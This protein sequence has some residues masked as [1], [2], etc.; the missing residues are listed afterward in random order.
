M[1]SCP[2]I[3][4]P[5]WQELK[6]HPDI[7]TFQAFKDFYESGS[8]R[9][10]QE[11][12][13]KI[14]DRQSPLISLVP[15]DNSLTEL[16]KEYD[17]TG[18][19]LNEDSI[20]NDRANEFAN[21]LSSS[22]GVDYAVITAE[23]AKTITKD[24]TNPWTGQAGFFF[25]GKVYFI[26]GKLTT[27]LVLHEFAHPV[28]RNIAKTN[29]A[30]LN[31]LF[32]QVL[33][34]KEG[35]DIVND[36][37]ENYSELQEGSDMFKEE[38]IV[39]ALE[40][41]AQNKLSN[42]K[43][44]TGFAKVI[45]N[46][47]YAIKQLLRKVFGK[48][49]KVSKLSAD[50][51]LGELADILVKGDLLTLDN[52]LI[53][54][55][56]IVAY[57]KEVIKALTEDIEHI[58]KDQVQETIN[59]FYD[60]IGNH[61]NMLLKNRNYEEL[62]R[63]LT[64]ESGTG[65]LQAM[66]G[67]LAAWQTTVIREAE[68]LQD[69]VSEARSRS[70]ALANTLFTLQSVMGKIKDHVLDIEK[71]KDTQ[72]N[73]HKAHY[74]EQMVNYW[75]G[76]I[77]EFNTSLIN[78]D[79]PNDS[80]VVSLVSGIKRDIEKSQGSI[81]RMMEAGAIDGLW[82]QLEP[83]NRNISER[84]SRMI[85]KLED[86][87]PDAS[88]PDALRKKIDT[89]YKEFH[90]M[91]KVELD[92][93]NALSKEFDE[94]GG[95]TVMKQ[96]EYDKLLA[97]T[98]EGLSVTK[99]KIKGLIKGQI[100][101]ANFFNSY[102]EG[103]L[104]NTDP[105]V[106]GL[107]LYTKNAI[108]EVM[109]VSQQKFNTFAEE[110]RPLL[111]KAGYNPRQVGKLG[112]DVGFLDT[113]S[114][115]DPDTK[116]LV[117]R[118]VWTLLNPFKN[119]RYDEDRLEKAVKDTYENYIQTNTK[120][121]E[122][123]HIEAKAKY[124]QWKQDYMHQEYIPEYYKRKELL[125]KDDLGKAAGAWMDDFFQRL[126]EVTEPN[127]TEI[128][129]LD[130]HDM[131]D[132]LWR[133][134]R[135]KF[136]MYTE[137]GQ[138]K[139]DL[140]VID[141]VTKR[142][143]PS[144]L[145]MAKRLREY[146]NE[147][148]EFYEWK[149]RKNAFEQAYRDFQ[150]ELLGEGIDEKHADYKTRMD[151]WKEKNTRKVIKQEYY[152]EKRRILAEIKAI[153]S[154]LDKKDQDELDQAKVWED[155]LDN[156]GGFRDSDGQIQGQE[157]AEGAVAT[158]KELQE[159]LLKLKKN[160]AGRSGLTPV[161]S[162]RL[163]EILAA[164]I[165]RD[166]TAQE[167]AEMRGYFEKRNNKGLNAVDRADLDRLYAELG[168]LSARESTEYYADIVN[169][170]LSKLNTKSLVVE[171]NKGSITPEEADYLLQDHVINP[172]LAQDA[173][174]AEWFEKNHIRVE[175]WNSTSKK[176]EMKWERLY[177]WNVTKPAD[178]NMQEKYEIKDSVGTVLDTVEG[179]PSM[180]Y[181]YR[182]VKPKYRTR[183]ITGV[184]KS[185]RGRWLPKTMAEKAKDDRYQNEEYYNLQKNNPALFAVLEKLKE[186]HL[187]NQE[188]L[189]YNA[190][191]Y[192]DFPRFQ[193][194]M[195]EGLQSKSPKELKEKGISKLSWLARRI[196][197]FYKREADDVQSGLNDDEKFNLVR[198]DMFDNEITNVPIAGLYNLDYGDVSTDITLS[199][200]RYMYSA[201]RQK[202]LIKISPFVRS[203][204]KTVKNPLNAPKDL[205]KVKRD[206]FVNRQVIKYLPKK[207]GANVRLRAI[208][209][210]ITREFEGQ[211]QTGLG[212]DVPWLNNLANLLFKRASFSFFALNI[213]SALKNS[214]GM[215]FQHMI[216][217]AGGE[218]IDLPNLGKGKLWAYKAMSEYSAKQLYQKRGALD[219]TQQIIE[220]FDPIQGRFEEKFGERLSRTAAADAASASWLY[221]FRKWVEIQAGLELFGGM[222]YKVKLNRTMP[223][224]SVEEIS[225]M[226]AWEVVDNQLQLK[227]GID[228]RYSNKP[229]EHVV[230]PEDT[231]ES[232]A[233]QYNMPL[234][235]MQDILKNKDLMI[236]TLEVENE[237]VNRLEEL[238]ELG[239]LES[240]ADALD[241]QKYQDRVDAVNRKYDEKIS[242]MGTIKINNSEFKFFKNRSQQVQNDMGGAYAK[243]DQP[244]A[245]RYLAFR[246]ISYLRRYFTT[247]MMNRFGFSG[248][249][250]AP[251]ERFNP[252]LGDS[253]MGFYIKTGQFLF[254]TIKTGGK[255]LPYMTETEKAAFIKFATEMVMLWTT[256]AMFAL[257]GWD[258]EDDDRY[259]K[260]R[261]ES[262]AL[263]FPFTADD[264]NREFNFNGFMKVQALHLLMQVRAENEQ[265]NMFT[266]GIQ[267][268]YSLTDV[269]S[270]ALGPTT[271]SY[272]QIWEDLK[273]ELTGNSKAKYSRKIGPYEWQQQ[274]GSKWLAHTATAVGLTGSSLDPAKAI[275]GFQSY[276]SK[277]KR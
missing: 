122:L 124:N 226:D 259:N 241:T 72:D 16:A 32:E 182:T 109:I 220:S 96:K 134:Y 269:K 161:E 145:A 180:E 136:S 270:V 207:Q 221:S 93:F 60:I 244:E 193:K 44:Q 80:P 85:K 62:A 95:L 195:L 139:S 37:L 200:M 173:E 272:M 6:N 260:L 256:M 88:N 218:Y 148:K 253:K 276:Q 274:G 163:S 146:R 138:M 35:R 212:A 275:Q 118:K 69:E 198:V 225:Y 165:D 242:K 215:K 27:D 20:K 159:K 2:N 149:V 102:L 17:L 266:G 4:S 273:N 68:K 40:K 83:I 61:I 201:E 185:N 130:A 92:R 89:L 229:I 179:L 262:G 251:R 247:M 112:E 181:Y 1:S 46:I 98:K 192:L 18:V 33:Q 245:Q 243:F 254:D 117:E 168:K 176:M 156:T 142:E 271:D 265:F 5:A 103:Y 67:N 121:A 116:E 235:A 228:A 258:P 57:N 141:P 111:E 128:D 230:K 158:I 232:L 104:Y 84:Y 119:Y 187:K 239:E 15:E 52:E 231:A 38:V 114:M 66:R 36:V 208:N 25:G 73:M 9:T 189:S 49:L 74:Y 48:D 56:E 24:A 233:K 263:P 147:G 99:E 65:D 202:Q 153:L 214:L 205:N 213:P 234:E 41:D 162:A 12:L 216:Q 39:K 76:F 135:Q 152:D 194:N 144:P 29:P 174:F 26:A 31:S 129:K 133:E 101:D 51:T 190:R 59:E 64:D 70:A 10:P 78:A 8:I 238:K 166:L 23:E 21:K 264:P 203:L 150:Q 227:S 45:N 160:V 106:G 197:G 169:N 236:I 126:R 177:L 143:T 79:V 75:D 63:L 107:A 131:V 91:T 125:Q 268:M 257:F 246:F 127:R 30:L 210:F 223:N 42:E 120:E 22:L 209:N 267:N 172:L 71:Q 113:V 3:N 175:K 50:T 240:T 137:N 191:L 110:M 237:E 13:K 14:Q 183:N 186:H 219:V 252:G 123:E 108:N 132:A 217:A 105:I 184:T 87:L 54:N 55:E 34:T 204:Q 81:S 261:A 224:G 255:Q 277:V 86:K 250:N 82:E 47:L 249:L 7:G 77:N 155:I 151:A 11:V 43:T 97:L 167:V 100:G 171:I 140:P 196:R 170:W 90:G 53:T 206:N 222:M 211:N 28:I 178:P 115:I 19:E 199:M 157:I 154:K 188:G 164:N 58:D 248:S 94:K